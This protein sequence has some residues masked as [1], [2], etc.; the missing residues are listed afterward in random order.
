[1]RS[2]EARKVSPQS[3]SLHLHRRITGAVDFVQSIF[4]SAKRTSSPVLPAASRHL[5]H[6]YRVY[7]ATTEEERIAVFQ[8]R[9]RVFNLELHEG[10]ESAFQNG[11]DRD[12][13]DAVCDHLVVE[14]QPSGKI[15]GTYRLQTGDSAVRNLGYY[16]ELEFQFD[17]YEGL[18]AQIVE[19]GRA[20]IHPDHRKYE[21]LM[22][23]WKGIARYATERG[24][25][26]LI[27][28]S[29]V[30]TQDANRGAALYEKLKPMLAPQ[31]LCTVPTPAYTSPTASPADGDVRP[32]KLL[33]TYLAV[34]ANI[35]GP[36]ALDREFKTI[37][38]L[39]LMDL[40]ALSPA[41]RSRFIDE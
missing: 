22:L 8:L 17:P 30:S 38:F 33:R 24:A 29:S 21:V 34:G 15:V 9:F 10:L 35:C 32:P 23:L 28:C 4:P 12:A 16:S 40:H 13:F 3:L 39:T 14:H 7:L 37:D 1:M 36:P 2:R 41:I 11:E 25:R 5:G 6:D 20:C 26:Y 18:R 31:E 27:G 19:L